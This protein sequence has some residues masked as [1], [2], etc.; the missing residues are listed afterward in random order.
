MCPLTS[1]Q[2]LQSL[3]SIA[4]LDSWSRRLAREGNTK[5]DVQLRPGEDVDGRAEG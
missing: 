2:H 5:L 3:F 4:L 1:V